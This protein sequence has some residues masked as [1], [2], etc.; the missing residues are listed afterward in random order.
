MD[1]GW[2]DPGAKKRARTRDGRSRCIFRSCPALKRFLLNIQNGL[3]KSDKRHQCVQ[4]RIPPKSRDEREVRRGQPLFKCHSLFRDI[5]NPNTPSVKRADSLTS[6]TN[7]L[8]QRMAAV[9]S[10]FHPRTEGK[11]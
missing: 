9:A 4:L 5:W 7:Q 6:L 10:D 11:A 8:A 2:P 3:T 1:I